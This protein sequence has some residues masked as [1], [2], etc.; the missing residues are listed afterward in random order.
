MRSHQCG[1]KDPEHPYHQSYHRLHP[2]LGFC[3]YVSVIMSS[4]GSQAGMALTWVP[5]SMLLLST[6]HTALISNHIFSNTFPFST[7]LPLPSSP[8]T[9]ES[10]SVLFLTFCN[11]SVK[12]GLHPAL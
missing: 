3:S 2:Q 11:D 10:Q 8:S 4:Y 9:L 6:K 5:V 12:A 1:S 7:G